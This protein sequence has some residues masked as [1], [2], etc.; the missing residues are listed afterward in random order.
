MDG[1][2]KA[3]GRFGF[4]L[5][6][7]SWDTQELYDRAYLVQQGCDLSFIYFPAFIRPSLKVDFNIKSKYLFTAYFFLWILIGLNSFMY[8][9]SE[10]EF[11][12][13]E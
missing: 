13:P 1:E 3:I 7:N 12:Q 2:G 6:L 8:G 4:S 11:L 10:N 9:S 5:Y